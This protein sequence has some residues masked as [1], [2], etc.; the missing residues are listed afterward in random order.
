MSVK[1]RLFDYGDD[2]L[3]AST[4]ML[5]RKRWPGD[6]KPQM[7]FGKNEVLKLSGYN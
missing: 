7:K 5:D 6:F 1:N 2:Q 3:A 4:R